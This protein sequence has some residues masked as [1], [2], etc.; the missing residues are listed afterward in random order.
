MTSSTPPPSSTPKSGL[1]VEVNALNT[2][3]ED[4]RTG[5]PRGLFRPWFAANVSVFGLSYGSLLRGFVLSFLLCGVIS[6][7][8]KRG[9]APTMVLS[10]AIF[11]INGNRLPSVLS[12][13]LTVGWETVL[14]ALAVLATSSVVTRLGWQG[15]TSAK[16][17][18]LV[19]V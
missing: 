16:L 7:A 15:G 9:S 4:E 2:I 17:I 18:S 8:G 5:R 13:L 12:W 6:L 14:T 1:S 3:G 19:V 11:G 10:R